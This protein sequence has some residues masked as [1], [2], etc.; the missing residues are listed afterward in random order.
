MRASSGSGTVP[1]PPVLDNLG[2]S[3]RARERVMEDG[4]VV[5]GEVYSRGG[6][7]GRGDGGDGRGGGILGQG[8]GQR[9]LDW[10][11][12]SWLTWMWFHDMV[13]VSARGLALW[14]RL[15]ETRVSTDWSA[16]RLGMRS[17]EE[18]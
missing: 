9:R 10:T 15:I 3:K 13:G 17:V 7:G 4:R 2:Q 1:R 12:M 18:L 16:N 14:L 11:R 5:L 6:R 8:W